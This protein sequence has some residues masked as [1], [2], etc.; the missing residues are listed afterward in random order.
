MKILLVIPTMQPTS[1]GPC[2]GIRN[3]VPELKK[4]G[5]VCEVLCFDDPNEP[6]ISKD[7]FKI[8]ALGEGR[9]SW[10]YN[11]KL[12]AWLSKNIE[13]YD[14]LIVHA[15][16]LYHTYAVH[17]VIKSLLNNKLLKNFKYYVM[18][19][20]MLD[21]YFQDAKER[22]VKA[23]RNVVYWNLIENKVVNDADGILFTCAEE[24]RL[25]KASFNNYH[26]KRVFNVGYGIAPPPAY[27]EEFK[28]AFN[29]LLKKTENDI[30]NPYILFLSR[31]HIKKGIDLLIDVY[32][33]ILRSSP[34]DN[35][36]DLVIAGPGIDTEF[37]VSIYKKI[38]SDAMLSSK[39]HFV[40][41]LSGDTKWGAFYGCEAFVLPSHQENF[42]IAV[43]E[44]LACGIPVLISDKINIWQEINNDGAG[45]VK[46][47]NKQG[48]LELLKE[49]IGLGDDKKIEMSDAAF[50]CYSI[51]FKN[52]RTA[53]ELYKIFQGNK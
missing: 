32:E 6:F 48:T 43:V 31:I 17:K 50:K 45:I 22:R 13:E 28:L 25:A 42:G 52:T 21:P 33:T 47:D 39:V 34:T 3:F 20:G 11:K 16:W 12:V 38:K 15:L 23:I 44:A 37:G 30:I 41:M 2:Q 4:L 29:K 46:S 51:H 9:G 53:S 7:S 14:S 49:W 1:G 8:H 24:M 35:I 26:P 40:G 10:Q 5:V 27:T 18:P 36:P 19:H